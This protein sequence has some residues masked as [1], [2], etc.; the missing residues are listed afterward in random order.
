MP[1]EA[2]GPSDRKILPERLRMAEIFD[3]I[4]REGSQLVLTLLAGVKDRRDFESVVFRGPCGVE[5]V[6][7]DQ[8]VLLFAPKC[9]AALR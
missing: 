5:G 6:F 3:V 8:N 7:K 9:S 1:R 4:V 2:F